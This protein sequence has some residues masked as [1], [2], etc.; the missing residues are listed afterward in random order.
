MAL[1]AQFFS[2]KGWDNIA[3]GNALG[4]RSILRSSLKGCDNYCPNLSGWPAFD[5]D[6]Q[7]VALGYVVPA[8]RA[9]ESEADITSRLSM[10]LH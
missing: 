8:L 2:P 10:A 1:R 4:W 7:G 3:Q 5:L 6:S 9:E